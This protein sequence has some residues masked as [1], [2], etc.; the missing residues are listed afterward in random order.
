MVQEAATKELV[1][2]LL[3]VLLALS[4]GGLSVGL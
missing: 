2:R 3:K 4:G 1:K